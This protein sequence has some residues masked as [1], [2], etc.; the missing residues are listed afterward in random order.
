MG[1]G[2]LRVR[3]RPDYRPAYRAWGAALVPLIFIAA[4]VGVVFY[5]VAADPRKTSVGL[6][7]VVLGLPLYYFWVR[8]SAASSE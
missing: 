2:L 1:I 7:L 6:L 8:K 5:Q 4:S 3:R